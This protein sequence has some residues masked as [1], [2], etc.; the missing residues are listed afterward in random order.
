MDRPNPRFSTEQTMKPKPTNPPATSMDS[1]K[2]RKQVL[3]HQGKTEEESE[4]ILAALVTS[5]DLAA[6]RVINSA[7][8]K[9]GLGKEIDLP[10]LMAELRRHGDA[11]NRGDLAQSEA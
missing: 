9:S 6:C 10:H 1:R 2:P 11:V 3:C 8:A 7:E 4:R 5:P